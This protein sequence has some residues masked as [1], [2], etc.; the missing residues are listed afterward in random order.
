MRPI[1]QCIGR[2][3]PVLLGELVPNV[4]AMIDDVVLAAEDTVA[5]P[6]VAD[7]RPDGLDRVQAL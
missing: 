4:A 2:D 5:Q 6:V 3:A 7:E 1:A